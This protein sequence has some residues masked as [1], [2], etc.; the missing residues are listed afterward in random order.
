MFL[1]CFGVGKAL[2]P[3]PESGV[4]ADFCRLDGVRN[5]HAIVLAETPT[6]CPGIATAALPQSPTHIPKHVEGMYGMPTQEVTPHSS[7]CLSG[8]CPPPIVK[9]CSL[10]PGDRNLAQ[11]SAPSQE[12]ICSSPSSYRQYFR[13]RPPRC[14]RGYTAGENA[15]QYYHVVAEISPNV[16]DS[17]GAN[18]TNSSRANVTNSTDVDYEPEVEVDW[19]WPESAMDFNAGR[20]KNA[21]GLP[22]LCE[23]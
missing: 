1:R 17:C 6:S 16:T 2:A 9:G 11:E 23:G 15:C 20:E 22:A 4:Q 21:G 14:K 5:G 19:N 3:E 18:V 13:P 7:L 8:P 12:S 10:H